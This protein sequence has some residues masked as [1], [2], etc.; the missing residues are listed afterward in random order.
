MEFPMLLSFLY[1]A[2]RHLLRIVAPASGDELSQEIEILVL[3]HQL[4]VL[5][6]GF[7]CRRNAAR[8]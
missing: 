1:F 5:V 6:R 3:H 4:R 8:A 7:T 2:L